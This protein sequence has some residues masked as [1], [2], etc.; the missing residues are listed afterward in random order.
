MLA[1]VEVGEG[2]VGVDAGFLALDD[3]VVPRRVRTDASEIRRLDSSRGGQHNDS[4][5]QKL[6]DEGLEPWTA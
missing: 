4:L 5:L 1:L 2:A 3:I 6:C